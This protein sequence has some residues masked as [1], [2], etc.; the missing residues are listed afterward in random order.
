[1]RSISL[2]IHQLSSDFCQVCFFIQWVRPQNRR[3]PMI[4]GRNLILYP[5]IRGFRKELTMLNQH[6]SLQLVRVE[7]R[8]A[9][10]DRTAEGDGNDDRRR[11]RRQAL[12][13]YSH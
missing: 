7:R 13:T 2:S 4:I 11:A 1:M 8:N 5:L 3:E 10:G 9:T 6:L 12:S